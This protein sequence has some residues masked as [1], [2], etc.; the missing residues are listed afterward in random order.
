MEIPSYKDI[1]VYDSFDERD[2]AEAFFEKNVSEAVEL[3]HESAF[4]SLE[5]LLWM[6]P[7][8]FCYYLPAAIRYLNSQDVQDTWDEYC[9]FCGSLKDQ[10]DYNRNEIA[11]AIP[12]MKVITKKLLSKLDE[13]ANKETMSQDERMLYK[14]FEEYYP[15]MRG[16]F[17]TLLNELSNE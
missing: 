5:Y 8:A 7:K 14:P 2:A 4:S 3:F 9:A 12:E 16:E 11:E 6:G 10:L 13:Y 1:N 17:V 15:E